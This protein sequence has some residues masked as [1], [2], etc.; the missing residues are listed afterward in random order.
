MVLRGKGGDRVLD[1]GWEA[2]QC[3]E[4]RSLADRTDGLG[5]AVGMVQSQT[6]L[7]PAISFEQKTSS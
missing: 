7:I 4:G 3:D 6:R 5:R 1:G 2:T